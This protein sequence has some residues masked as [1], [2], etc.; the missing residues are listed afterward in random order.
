[1]LLIILN[2][3]FYYQSSA[4]LQSIL[5]K[6]YML[7]IYLIAGVLGVM[8]FFSV[9]VAPS[10]FKILPQEWAGVY[11]R[12]FFPKYYAVLGVAC[13]VAALFTNLPALKHVGLT[14]AALFAVS[15]FI[16]TPR[17]NA[18]KD[19]NQ[20]KQFN[21]MHGLSVGVN[22]LQLVL[23]IYALYKSVAYFE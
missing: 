3:F 9:A 17:V 2:L 13:L 23:L 22:L 8:L 15:L 21:I 6:V 4:K 7:S 11:V 14:C 1:M 20:T 10:I 18:A 16:L 5:S 12:A 19:N